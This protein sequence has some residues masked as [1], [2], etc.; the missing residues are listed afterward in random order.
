MSKSRLAL[1]TSVFVGFGCVGLL[2]ASK[3]A[4]VERV[5]APAT[6]DADA[7]ALTDH[8]PNI[9]LTTQEG[10]RV[11]FYDDLVKGRIVTINFMYTAC[12]GICPRE[13]ANLVQV[14]RLL[15]DRV[16]RD[17]RM[18]SISLEPDQDTPAALRAYAAR[19]KVKPGWTFLTGKKEDIERL[20]RK[21]G[22]Y[23]PD[24]VVDQDK[25]QHAGLLVMGNE[26]TGRWLVQPALLA[27]ADLVWTLHRVIDSRQS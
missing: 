22:V 4:P 27:P 7:P 1:M 5:C 23:D 16:G 14:Q 21:L 2:H 3:R 26:P 24:P 25:T 20:R 15:G 19:H 17:I 11:C 8:L 9:P 13:T 6:A 18:L 12:T 10:Q